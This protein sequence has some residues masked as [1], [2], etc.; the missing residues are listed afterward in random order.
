MGSIMIQDQNIEIP[1]TS[2]SMNICLWVG[3]VCALLLLVVC[4]VMYVYPEIFGIIAVTNVSSSTNYPSSF[5]DA[6]TKWVV[7]FNNSEQTPS[8]DAKHH[9]LDAYTDDAV[10]SVTTQAVGGEDF[11]A[12][13]KEAIVSHWNTI[14]KEYG[15]KIGNAQ[16]RKVSKISD[17]V[18]VQSYDNVD[19]FKDGKHTISIR[20]LAEVWKLVDGKWKVA[21]DY[22]MVTKTGMRYQ[23]K[24]TPSFDAAATKWVTE[25]NA[26]EKVASIDASHHSLNAYTDDSVFSVTLQAIE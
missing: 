6:A 11:T 8:L 1:E 16:V 17:T 9:G 4:I 20:I 18:L 7:E 2:K 24:S 12:R 10:F 26:S 3:W 21:A 15:G 14:R 19:F 25:F 13:G 5:D 22:V 23:E